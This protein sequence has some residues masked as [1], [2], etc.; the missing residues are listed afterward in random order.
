MCLSPSPASVI[1]S[2][3][4]W[5]FSRA[6]APRSISLETTAWWPFAA[7]WCSA[8]RPL[9]SCRSSMSSICSCSTSCATASKQPLWAARCSALCPLLFRCSRSASASTSEEARPRLLAKK[10]GDCPT[11]SAA[12]TFARC[13]SSSCA[14]RA[15]SWKTAVCSGETSFAS[16][17]L[18]SALRLSNFRVKS[19]LECFTANCS[20]KVPFSDRRLGSAWASRSRST[21]SKSPICTA[22]SITR[23]S[24]VRRSPVSSNVN[25]LGSAR[26][27]SS[28]RRE[29][30]LPS[31]GSSPSPRGAAG[32]P[33]RLLMRP[34]LMALR[35]AAKNARS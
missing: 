25:E 31:L 27:S 22:S 33:V 21:F 29:G 9:S 10:T 19:T 3:P 32:S 17:W 18:T 30:F 1:A 20:G 13:R 7:A 15:S 34:P 26:Y 28:F 6:S 23:Q 5:V 2:L 16:C 24:R 4:A 12:L 35:C 8:V 14:T 11:W